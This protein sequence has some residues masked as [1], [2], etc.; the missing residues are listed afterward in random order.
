MK[1][2]F[3]WGNLKF[4]LKF[5]FKFFKSKLL[6][7]NSYFFVKVFVKYD[8]FIHLCSPIEADYCKKWSYSS[9][10]S[11]HLP[12]KQGVLGSN[13]SG[14]TKNLSNREVFLFLYYP[15]FST[16]NFHE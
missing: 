13:P 11:E 1:K 12:Y 6:K 10:G 16:L 3:P 9:A 2:G 5:K 8:F 14:T 7:K 4:I 15:K